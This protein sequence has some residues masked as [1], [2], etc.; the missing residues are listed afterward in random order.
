MA[1]PTLVS[2]HAR[3]PHSQ[4]AWMRAEVK[5]QNRNGAPTT[6]VCALIRE[7]VAALIAER[8]ALRQ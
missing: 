8:K 6:N 4:L 7:A 3:L 1:A 5:R 2:F